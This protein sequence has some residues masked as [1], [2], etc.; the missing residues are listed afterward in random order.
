ML[1]GQGYVFPE[2]VVARALE[3]ARTV[4]AL[5]WQGACEALD[6]AWEGWEADFLVDAVQ[7][8]MEARE[9]QRQ[10]DERRRWAQMIG[11]PRVR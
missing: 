10:R 8:W 2:P 5:G 4:D 1:D 9:V 3:V 7:V 11:G 6:E